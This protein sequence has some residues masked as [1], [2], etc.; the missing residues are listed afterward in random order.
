MAT[1]TNKPP[2]GEKTD[3]DKAAAATTTEAP[4]ASAS[5][6][7]PSGDSQSGASAPP[8][9][10]TAALQQEVADL[11]AMVLTLADAVQAKAGQRKVELAPLESEIGP[12]PAGKRRLLSPYEVRITGP[13]ADKFVQPITVEAL[14]ESQAKAR[15]AKAC[16]IVKTGNT[17][18]AKRLGKTW[19]VD[20]KDEKARGL[21]FPRTVAIDTAEHAI[22]VAAAVAK[23]DP[24]KLVA[25]PQ[26]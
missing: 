21:D 14:G 26:S 18:T 20:T 23:V 12:L 11:K 1:T 7:S 17:L 16:G 9:G 2:A 19:T 25:T 4:E 10:D 24:A 5:T 22:E 6:P 15:V 13:D 8:A 3:A